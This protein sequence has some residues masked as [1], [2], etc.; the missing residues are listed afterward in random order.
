[1]SRCVPS[2]IG[3]GPT[4]TQT[5]PLSPTLA[6]S[7]VIDGTEIDRGRR[8]GARQT[9]PLGECPRVQLRRGDDAAAQPVLEYFDVNP[10][11][12]PLGRYVS[13]IVGIRL[14]VFFFVFVTVLRFVMITALAASGHSN[15]LLLTWS[16]KDR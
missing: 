16:S 7:Y 1:L 2:A 9:I 8:Y 15:L 10:V 12:S 6:L 11:V 4:G 5:V 3:L 14:R 13:P